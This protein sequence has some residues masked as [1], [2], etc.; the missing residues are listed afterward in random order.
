MPN[1]GPDEY[2]TTTPALLVCPCLCGPSFE[3]GVTG[4]LLGACVLLS[5]P[6]GCV[7]VVGAS[8]FNRLIMP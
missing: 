4:D 1:L 8:A 2:G 6:G 7:G 3:R 5:S